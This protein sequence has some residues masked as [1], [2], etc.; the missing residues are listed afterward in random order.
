[1]KTAIKYLSIIFGII[2]LDQI[3]KSL[4]LYLITGTVPMAGNA[5]GVVGYPYLM[6]HVFD[7]FNIVF[8]WNPGTSFSL[9]RELG[10]GA[11]CWCRVT[12]VDDGNESSDVDG[13]W[14]LG[15]VYGSAAVCA[16]NCAVDCA[17]G[18]RYPAFRSA[19]FGM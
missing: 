5:W 11:K 12:G 10:D 6:A 9:F 4:L 8:T 19:V 16:S 14:V 18:V 17:G 15:N 1:M 7:W 3:V 13:V 2:L